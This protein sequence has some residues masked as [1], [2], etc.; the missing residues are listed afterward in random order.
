MRTY[1]TGDMHGYVDGRFDRAAM[2]GL[3]VEEGDLLVVLGDMGALFN[4]L[5]EEWARGE[6]YLTD[7]YLLTDLAQAWPGDVAF[8]DGNHENHPVLA[9]L[10]RERRWGGEVGV[11]T[12]GLYHLR[13]GGTYRLPAEDGEATAWCMGGAWSIDQAGRT[14][15]VD[16]WPEEV[17]DW[18]E[19]EAARE[20]LAF[21]GWK[22][23]YILTH[24]C[25]TSM[26]AALTRDSP[27]GPVRHTDRLQG[28]LEEVDGRATFGRWYCGH[29]H[30]NRDVGGSHTCLYRKVVPLGEPAG[31]E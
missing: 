6:M 25:P 4:T 31:E 20:S 11:V 17:P 22:V 13:R 10:P 21:L 9:S 23:D 7:S 1:V 5:P 24:E 2:E 28:F 12:E 26:R 16:W 30:V 15:G 27:F 29:Y 19:I 8:V 3:G 14:E 18:G